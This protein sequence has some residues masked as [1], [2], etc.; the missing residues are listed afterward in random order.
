MKRKYTYKAFDY[1]QSCWQQGIV[2]AENDTEAALIL[3]SRGWQIARLQ[4][5]HRNPLLESKNWSTQQ[6]AFLATQLATLL[7]AD[8]DLIKAMEM[9]AGLRDG[10]ARKVLLEIAEQIR[11]G[12]SAA[13]AL[14]ESG[15]FPLLF[16]RL[17]EV[18]EYSGTLTEN[19]HRAA[20]Y[21]AEQNRIE[22][23]WQ[24]ALTY[25]AMVLVLAAV[26]LVILIEAILPTFAQL[27]DE[28]GVN[29][30]EVTQ[31][32]LYASERLNVVFPWILGAVILV[33]VVGLCVKD[34]PSI[35]RIRYAVMLHWKP[36]R[37]RHI[38]VLCHV[39]GIVLQSGIDVAQGLEIAGE[40]LSD[41][42]YGA[43]LRRAGQQITQGMTPYQSL[44]KSSIDDEVL[45]H[46]VDIGTES[47]RL[48]EMLQ[49]AGRFYDEQVQA[50]TQ[51]YKSRIGPAV[52]V[53]V[54]VIVALVMYGMMMPIL[55]TMTM[56]LNG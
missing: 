27:F 43:R 39:W 1:A 32:L 17:V 50:V 42:A 12:Q 53:S 15:V 56:P 37:Y 29:P 22:R 36:Y 47:G 25:P 41:S 4:R 28:L 24:E 5:Y 51:L 13:Y 9:S 55:E 49:E 54:G 26:V 16:V 7:T 10:S 45:L 30:S 34:N 23:A 18:G 2:S 31:H 6:T 44:R 38:A 11:S 3:R 8:V 33:A 35:R 52:L 21:F 20:H 40:T 46:M 19:L 48:S 14:Q